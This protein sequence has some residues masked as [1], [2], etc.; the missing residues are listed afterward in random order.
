MTAL[1]FW[2]EHDQLSLYVLYN[3]KYYAVPYRKNG[4]RGR[5]VEKG[6]LSTKGIKRQVSAARAPGLCTYL[7]IPDSITKGLEK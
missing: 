5:Q 3:A 1:L 7:G 2:S 4:W 6:V